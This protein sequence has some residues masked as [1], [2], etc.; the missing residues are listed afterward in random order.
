MSFSNAGFQLVGSEVQAL[1]V[2]SH[3]ESSARSV[4]LNAQITDQKRP[5]S[6]QR[7]TASVVS[8]QEQLSPNESNVNKQLLKQYFAVVWSV[9]MRNGDLCGN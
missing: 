1:S 5:G 3:S 7:S 9:S 2:L 4:S 6:S 8:F